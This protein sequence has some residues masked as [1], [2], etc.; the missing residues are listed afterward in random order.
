MWPTHIIIGYS[1]DA[2]IVV[3]Q[4]KLSNP[5]ATDK[6][7]ASVRT[8]ASETRTIRAAKLPRLYPEYMY[9]TCS[10]EAE[11]S[12]KEIPYKIR[13]AKDVRLLCYM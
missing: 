12:A 5:G 6:T 2:P 1:T 8:S 3:R 9:T 10:R 7:Q 4:S 13:S 11:R